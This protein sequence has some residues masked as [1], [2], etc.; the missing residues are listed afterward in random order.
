VGGA[1]AAA[2][3]KSWWVFAALAR[4]VGV[5]LR[6]LPSLNGLSTYRGATVAVQVGRLR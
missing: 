6:A 4:P 5:G 1:Q 3:S 2:V